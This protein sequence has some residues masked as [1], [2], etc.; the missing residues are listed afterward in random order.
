MPSYEIYYYY[1]STLA[2]T[3]S[4]PGVPWEACFHVAK[5]VPYTS[6]SMLCHVAAMSEDTD[7]AQHTHYSKATRLPGLHLKSQRGQLPLYPLITSCL[8]LN[9]QYLGMEMLKQAAI[10]HEFIYKSWWLLTIPHHINNISVS[11]PV[12]Y[13]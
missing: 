7:P 12:S 10:L 2:L 6:L 11:K 9:V 5:L 4:H 13:T 1:Y 3:I 8:I